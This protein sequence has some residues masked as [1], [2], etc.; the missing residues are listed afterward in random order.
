MNNKN[1]QKSEKIYFHKKIWFSWNG[2]SVSEYLT[3]KM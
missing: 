1:P 3:T 2:I